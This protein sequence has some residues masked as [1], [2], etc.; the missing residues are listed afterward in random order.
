MSEQKKRKTEFERVV[1][2]GNKGLLYSKGDWTS[3]QAEF[4]ELEGGALRVRVKSGPDQG[5]TLRVPVG[6]WEALE[7]QS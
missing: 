1:I 4:E 2:V 3:E 7:K 5:K 6:R